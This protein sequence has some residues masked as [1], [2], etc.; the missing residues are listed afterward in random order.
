MDGKGGGEEGGGVWGVSRWRVDTR[1]PVLAGSRPKF[2][3]NLINQHI[4][5]LRVLDF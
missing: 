2:R 3:I 1:V 5:A 4:V